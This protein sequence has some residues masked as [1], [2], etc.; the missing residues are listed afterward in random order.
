MV[1]AAAGIEAKLARAM[2]HLVAL[3]D[4]VGGYLDS[5]PVSLQR[6]VSEDGLTNY[7][8]LNAEPV[9]TKIPVLI[10]EVAHQLRSAIEHVAD[11][12][13]AA[14]GKTPTNSTVFPVLA[15]KKRPLT[16]AGG[17]LP[18]ALAQVEAVQP[19]LD[20]DPERHPLHVLHRLWNVDKHRN[21]HVTAAGLTHSQIFVS[22][23]DGSALLGGQLQMK[24]LRP[25]DV[26]GVF[27]FD[28]PLTGKET[29]QAIGQTFV[30]LSEPGPWSVDLPVAVVLGELYRYVRDELLP[31]FTPWI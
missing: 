3:D 10:G 13:V 28:E 19:Y 11:A 4:A 5:G 24:V 27:P 12:L 9:P 29:V 14:S 8:V 31:R 15:K 18:E 1:N 22:S 23:E 25:G 21:L 16:V 6:G 2:E 20:P 17:V 26:V 7:F 30:A